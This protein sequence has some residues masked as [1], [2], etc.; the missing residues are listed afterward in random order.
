MQQLMESLTGQPSFKVNS[1]DVINQITNLG[2]RDYEAV[3]ASIDPVS[4]D[5]VLSL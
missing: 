5:T 3:M 1:T 2:E 4:S